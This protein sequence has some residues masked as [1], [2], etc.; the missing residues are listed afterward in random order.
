M[1]SKNLAFAGLLVLAAIVLMNSFSCYKG[2]EDLPK[3]K[4]AFRSQIEK[5]EKQKEDTN[6]KMVESITKLTQIEQALENAKNKDKEF[7]RIYNRWNG[8]EKEVNRLTKDY[9]G[10]RDDAQ[11]LFDAL[12]RQTSGLKDATR[13][14]ELTNALNKVRTDYQKT[15]TKTEKS[16]NKLQALYADAQDLVQAL[17]VS[18]A[19]GEFESFKTGMA[20]IEAQVPGL[21]DELNEVIKESKDLYEKK[22]GAI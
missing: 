5:F 8:V 3:F 6:E 11:N 10:L 12:E 20:S 18:V 1:N 15:L 7:K 21:M 4:K 13:R 14:T 9:E 22:M 19:L 2:P 17:E 16:I